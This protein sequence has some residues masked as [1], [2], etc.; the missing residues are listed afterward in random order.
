MRVMI[1][2]CSYL[3][4]EYLL[5]LKKKSLAL[6]SASWFCPRPRGFVLVLGLVL[7]SLASVNITAVLWRCVKYDGVVGR[8]KFTPYLVDLVNTGSLIIPDLKINISERFF[9]PGARDLLYIPYSGVTTL[10]VYG[11][12]YLCSFLILKL[13]MFLVLATVMCAR[14]F[15]LRPRRWE[16]WPR[17]SETLVETYGE[18]HWAAQIWIGSQLLF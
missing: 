9:D 1:V 18:T 12:P 4:Y 10:H 7:R 17:R 11:E 16:F 6:S 15:K 3:L 2:S 13:F 8:H 5:K 14:P